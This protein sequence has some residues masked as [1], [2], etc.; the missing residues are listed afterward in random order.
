MD[1]VRI[2]MH[3]HRSNEITVTAKAA[4]AARP[5]S[6]SGLMLV[7]APRTPAAGTS[8]GAGRARDVGLLGFV[9]KARRCRVRTPDS[10]MRPLW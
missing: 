2:E 5:V 7:P 10:A 8:F 9:G 6:A 1:A 3:I 4:L